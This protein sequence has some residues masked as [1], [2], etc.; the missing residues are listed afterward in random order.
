MGAPCRQGFPS[1]SRL[2]SSGDYVSLNRRGKRCHTSHLLIIAASD[3]DELRL[4]ISVSR[5]VGNAVCRNRLKRWTREYFRC[6]RGSLKAGTDISV[7]VKQGAA[8]LS[9]IE[10]DRQL[11]E[12]LHKL[13]VIADA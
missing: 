2:R 6:R 1:S 5:K 10:Y 12:G 7:V 3:G 11:Q 13:Q 4:G 9:H 8:Q